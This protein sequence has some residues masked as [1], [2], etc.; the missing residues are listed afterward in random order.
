MSAPFKPP[1]WMPEITSEDHRVYV[2]SEVKD[3]TVSVVVPVYNMESKGY[4]DDLLESLAS[5]S[6]KGIEFLLVDDA[7]T[8]GSLER[9]LEFAEGRSDTSV[10]SMRKNS[11]QG[12]ARNRGIIHA[13]GKYVGF[14]DGDDVVEPDYYRGMYKK[15]METGAEIVTAPYVHASHDLSSRG[16]IVVPLHDVGK[17]TIDEELRG[18]LILNPF[19]IW[20]AIYAKQLFTI[21]HALFPEGMFFEDNPGAFRLLMAASS[22]E[23]VDPEAAGVYIYRINQGSTMYRLDQFELHIKDR[24]VT[25]DMLLTDAEQ[26]GITGKHGDAV[27]LYYLHMALLASLAKFSEAGR[28]PSSWLRQ[29]MRHVRTQ[30]GPIICNSAL[31][32][33]PHAEAFKYLFAYYCPALFIRFRRLTRKRISQHD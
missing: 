4:L 25:S 26:C 8:D 14:V 31:K 19:H 2:E 32:S 20:A 18:K 24:I 30:S 22:I 21:S 1:V 7:S 16:S 15:A 13:R 12:A 3:P 10:I 6:L 9:M 11:R 33:R 23:S 29:M 27:R 5:Q 17:G 28:Y